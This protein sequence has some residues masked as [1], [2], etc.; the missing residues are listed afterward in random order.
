MAAAVAARLGEQLADYKV[1]RIYTV[2]DELTKGA[3]GKILK[4]ELRESVGG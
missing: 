4:R 3:T 2:V 1:P